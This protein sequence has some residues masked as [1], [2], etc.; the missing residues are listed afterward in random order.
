[1]R[2]VTIELVVF[3]QVKEYTTMDAEDAREVLTRKMNPGHR[4]RINPP[5]K[6]GVFADDEARYAAD[7]E[8]CGVENP[9]ANV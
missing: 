9:F 3:G 2:K 1:M 7:C 8:A 5:D 4:Y 6:T